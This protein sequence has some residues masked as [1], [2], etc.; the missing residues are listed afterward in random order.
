M[1]NMKS[2]LMVQRQ[3]T[4]ET[5]CNECS[6][7]NK[8]EKDKHYYSVVGCA[9]GDDAAFP[10][11][12]NVFKYLCVCAYWELVH[13]CIF[14]VFLLQRCCLHTA[15]DCM[16]ESVCASIPIYSFMDVWLTAPVCMVPLWVNRTHFYTR[17]TP[18]LHCLYVSRIGLVVSISQSPIYTGRCTRRKGTL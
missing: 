13:F 6:D 4:M 16:W 2:N 11:S 1:Q 17:L 12:N 3:W 7:G 9:W 14:C 15:V 10:Q 5:T 8:G 18:S